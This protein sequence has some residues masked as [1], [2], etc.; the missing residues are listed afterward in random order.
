M[1]FPNAYKGISR[2]LTAQWIQLICSILT[3][4]GAVLTIVYSISAATTAEASLKAADFSTLTGITGTIV[5]VAMIFGIIAI[6]M[7]LVGISNARKDDSQFSTAFILCIIS[8]ILGIVT[9]GIQFLNPAIAG[10]L[11]FVQ[12][13]LSL[14]VIEYVVAGITSLAKQLKN[15]DVAGLGKSIRII[16][17]ILY[18]IAIIICIIGNV[19]TSLDNILS[20]VEVV[21]EL[22]VFIAYIVLLMKEK[23]M[24]A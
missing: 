24:L 5:F 18:C 13:V 21:L 1:N 6:I 3:I 7:N 16:I 23:R 12:N 15:E 19:A 10:W 11:S 14:A 17:T 9:G 22:V 20:V 8:L 4:I 2:I